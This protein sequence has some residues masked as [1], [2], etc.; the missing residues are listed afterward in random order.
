M[1]RK[2]ESNRYQQEIEKNVFWMQRLVPLSHDALL[3]CETAR[4]TV[5]NVSTMI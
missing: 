1:S 5:K 3:S 4:I 2:S